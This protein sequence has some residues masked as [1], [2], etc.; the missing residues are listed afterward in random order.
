MKEREQQLQ[1]DLNKERRS[2]MNWK[3]VWTYSRA[4]LRTAGRN[5]IRMR[6]RRREPASASGFLEWGGRAK[7]RHRFGFFRSSSLEAVAGKGKSIQSAVAASLCRRPPNHA[8][9]GR[10]SEIISG[11]LPPPTHL[12]M[13]SIRTMTAAV[14]MSAVSE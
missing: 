3:V 12:R 2:L 6:R 5:W 1:T 11:R 9:A 10:D 14:M 4:R 7:R 8:S 13:E